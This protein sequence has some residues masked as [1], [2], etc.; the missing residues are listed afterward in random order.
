[1]DQQAAECLCLQLSFVSGLLLPSSVYQQQ[2]DV[3]RPTPEIV[4]AYL[5]RLLVDDPALFLER[6]N[7]T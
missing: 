7:M 5:S 4:Q 2:Q 6:Y 1:M 3:P